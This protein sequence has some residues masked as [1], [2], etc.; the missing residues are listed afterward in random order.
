[1]PRWPGLLLAILLLAGLPG[2]GGGGDGQADSGDPPQPPRTPLISPDL[3]THQ[4]LFDQ[5]MDGFDR[6]NAV[7]D[8]ID[9]KAAAESGVADIDRAC[10][11]L[12]QTMTKI[13]RLEP[14]TQEQQDALMQ[15]YQPKLIASA[16]GIERQVERIRSIDVEAAKTVMLRIDTLKRLKGVTPEWM[17]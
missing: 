5:L 13:N 8:E 3:K 11:G 15:V 9:S 1:M 2:C 4:G 10:D 7:L 17:R 6:L 12:V 16:E 14:I